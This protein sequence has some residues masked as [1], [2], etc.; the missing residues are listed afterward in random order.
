MGSAAH[1]ARQAEARPG[2]YRTTRASTLC[3]KICRAEHKTTA[4]QKEGAN[5]NGPSAGT[6]KPER[7]NS[8]RR[9]CAVSMAPLGR[10]CRSSERTAAWAGSASKRARRYCGRENAKAAI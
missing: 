7:G 3:R 9:R 8:K 6:A 4:R 10:F 5:L 1:A 2:A